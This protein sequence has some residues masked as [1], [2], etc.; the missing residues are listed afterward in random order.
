MSS[1]RDLSGGSAEGFDRRAF[2]RTTGGVATGLAVTAV[3]GA[4]VLS[5]PTAADAKTGEPV[6]PTGDMP[7]EPVMAYVHNAERGEVTVLFGTEQR[8]YRDPALA[9]RLLD[10]ATTI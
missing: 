6:H 10:A 7:S 2:L 4:A 5:A 9:K 1:D 3:P 8:T